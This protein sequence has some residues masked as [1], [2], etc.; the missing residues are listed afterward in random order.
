MR[1]K[2]AEALLFVAVLL[3]YPLIYYVTATVRDFVYQYPIHPE[4]LALA[5]SVLTLKEGTVKSLRTD[6][7]LAR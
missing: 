2:N 6:A 1:S 7:E 3:F 4:M 5:A